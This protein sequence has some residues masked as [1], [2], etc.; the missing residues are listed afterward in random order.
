MVTALD[1]PGLHSGRRPEEVSSQSSV[2]EKT[3]M[4]EGCVCSRQVA[5]LLSSDDIYFTHKLLLF[6]RAFPSIEW[7]SNY[8]LASA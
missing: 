5:N 6:F 3:S 1:S 8:L 2:R 4:R 7:P